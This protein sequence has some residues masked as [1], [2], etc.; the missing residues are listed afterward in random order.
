MI[1]IS[2]STRPLRLLFSRQRKPTVVLFGHILDGNLKPFL[3]YTDKKI[4]F[5]YNVYYLTID[6]KVYNKLVITHKNKI[7]LA[8]KLSDIIKIIDSNCIITSHGPMIFYLLHFLIPKIHF[9][10]VWHGTGF[11]NYTSDAFKNMKFYKS[12]FVSSDAWKK[13]YNQ[14]RGFALDRIKVTGLAKH[15]VFLKAHDIALKVRSELNL[16]GFKYIV[17]YAPTWRRKGEIGELPFNQTKEIFFNKM[18]ILAKKLNAVI[19]LRTHINSSIRFDSVNFSNLIYL[20][21]STYPDTNNLLTIVDL[22]ITDW[23]N[24]ATDYC[25]LDRPI[26]FLDTPRPANHEKFGD[27]PMP[28]LR[29]GIIARNMNELEKEV[30]DNLGIDPDDIVKEQKIMKQIIFGNM[31]DGNACKR[32]DKEIRRLIFNN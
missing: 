27:T 26:I 7:L 16:V 31:L 20:N 17:L 32:Y 13:I 3:R 15:D 12:Y 22:L 10:D 6:R 1:I 25:G 9:I 24:I 18:N 14:F 30:S 11:I 4:N 21:Q 5:P 28:I 2:W 23:S 8:T 19:I 29:G